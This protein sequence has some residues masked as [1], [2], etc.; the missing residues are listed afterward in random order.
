MGKLDNSYIRRCL[1][2]AEKAKGFTA[3]NPMVGAVLVKDGVVIGEGYHEEHGSP[4]AEV[5]AI[6]NAKVDVK[7]ATLYCSLEPCCH[8]KKLTPPCTDLIIESGIKRVVVA[9]LDPNPQV[10]GKGLALLERSG[11]ETSYGFCEE[12]AEELNKVFFK[13]VKSTLPYIHL[14]VALTLDGRIA[15]TSGDSR[16]ISSDSSRALVHDLRLLYDGVMIG[17]NTLNLD[18]PRLTARRGETILKKPIPIIIGDPEKF[19]KDLFLL[20]ESSNLLLLNTGHGK[21]PPAFAKDCFEVEAEKSL[22]SSFEWLKEQGVNS[23][24]VEGGATLISSLIEEDLYDEMTLFICPKLI[25]NGP[26]FFNSTLAEKMSD[27]KVLKGN[28]KQS[29]TGDIIFEVRKN[30]Y[31]SS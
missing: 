28:A 23:I 12:E 1:Q 9:T 22:A 19:K 18:D 17:R 4:H 27:A 14:K 7:G 30:V 5:N 16:W 15:S 6:N 25:G 3:P 21:T 26:S 10:A 8:T 13:S 24:L 20:K 29:N 2:L 11:I 31:R